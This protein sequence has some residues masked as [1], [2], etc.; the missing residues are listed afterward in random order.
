MYFA[1]DCEDIT[2]T[3]VKYDAVTLNLRRKIIVIKSAVHLCA[4]LICKTIYTYLSK[5][6]IEKCFV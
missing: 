3:L 6:Y 2:T 4:Y 1:L 5:L